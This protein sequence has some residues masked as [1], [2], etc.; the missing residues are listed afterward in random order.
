M[1]VSG[2]SSSTSISWENSSSGK[3]SAYYY[4]LYRETDKSMWEKKIKV[5][6]NSIEIPISKDNY[7]FAVQAVD[8]NGHESLP[9]FI[10]RSSK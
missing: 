3:K 8:S 6:T 1:D 4:V 10:T 9:I 5:I 7:L 2:L